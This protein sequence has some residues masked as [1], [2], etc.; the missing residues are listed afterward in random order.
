[1]KISINPIGSPSTIP[2]G[3]RTISSIQ[4]YFDE[5][6]EPFFALKYLHSAMNEKQSNFRWIDATIAAELAIKE[7]LIRLKPD[8]E[9]LILEPPS[10][11]L[12]KLYGVVF[13]SLTGQKSRKLK[14]IREGATKRNRLVH[15][16][17]ETNIDAQEAHEYIIDIETAIYHSLIAVFIRIYGTY[18]WEVLVPKG[19]VRGIPYICSGTAL[20]LKKS[21]GR[22]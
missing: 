17:T 1:M 4:K 21:V 20:R 9:K 16:P 13:E 10:P 2:I 6:Q 7:F 8:I 18:E 15:K 11:P 3:E 14:G 12:Y 22:F 5:G 19:N